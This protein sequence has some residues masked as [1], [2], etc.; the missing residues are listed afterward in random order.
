MDA[1]MKRMM[2]EMNASIQ[3]LAAQTQASIQALATQTQASIQ[4]LAMQTEASIQGLTTEMRTSIKGLEG[5][6][7]G[8]E[9]RFDSME[10]RL[11]RK[12]NRLAMDFVLSEKRQEA[13]LDAAVADMKGIYNHAAWAA[14]SARASSEKVISH[15]PMLTD[16]EDR[17]RALEGKRKTPPIV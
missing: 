7:D 10:N 16:H 5:G 9:G 12:F 13:K 15:G 2:A 3:G 8:L 1:D 14:D 11:D 17:I 6:F 4:A